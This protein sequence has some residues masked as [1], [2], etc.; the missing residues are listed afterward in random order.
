[1]SRPPVLIACP[2]TAGTLAAVR[3]LGRAG[4][5]V[6]VCGEGGVSTARWSR[7]TRAYWGFE[8]TTSEAGYLTGLRTW[9]PRAARHVLLPASDETAWL[10]ARHAA[11]LER[12]YTVYAPRLDI[13]ETIL[14]K[15]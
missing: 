11:E 3:T 1:M 14:D 6:F 9:A 12:H 2:T 7:F 15:Q 4:V 10:F 8:S 5:P 13:V